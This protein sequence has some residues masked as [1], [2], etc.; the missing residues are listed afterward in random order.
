[1]LVVEEV[2][3]CEMRGLDAA[4]AAARETADGTWGW[5]LAASGAGARTWYMLALL[6]F[7]AGRFGVVGVAGEVGVVAVWY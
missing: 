4:L 6:N 5:G 2:W 1:M 3:V 7:D